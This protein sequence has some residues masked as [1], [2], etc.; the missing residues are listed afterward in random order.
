MTDIIKFNEE[1]TPKTEIGKM[2]FQLAEA[3]N[4]ITD[5]QNGYKFPK[6]T[7]TERYKKFNKAMITVCDILG[8]DLDMHEMMKTGSEG[9]SYS[10]TEDDTKALER[11]VSNNRSHDI[12]TKL[13]TLFTLASGLSHSDMDFVA[14]DDKGAETPA[15]QKDI[16]KALRTNLVALTESLGL[17]VDQVTESRVEQPKKTVRNTIEVL[18]EVALYPH[19]DSTSDVDVLGDIVYSFVTDL[20]DILGFEEDSESHTENSKNTIKK[21]LQDIYSLNDSM[22]TGYPNHIPTYDDG[23]VIKQSDLADMNM[24]AL[25]SIAEMLG[26]E[27]E[28]GATPVKTKNQENYDNLPA[29]DKLN[30]DMLNKLHEVQDHVL[31][32]GQDTVSMN[33]VQTAISILEGSLGVMEKV[34][35]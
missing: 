5:L 6:L 35:E 20:K 33:Q 28:E 2:K 15:S 17:S 25:D 24:N 9:F 32:S 30:V 14:V 10:D 26:F 29:E 18:E 8:I 19:K 34:E 27:L 4:T 23:T 13:F 7:A 31:R 1:H 12:K 21:Q 16:T 3:L 11:L 22:I